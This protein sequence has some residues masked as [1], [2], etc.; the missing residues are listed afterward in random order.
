MAG[1]SGGFGQDDDVISGIN[2]TPLVDVVLVLL[3]IFMITAPAIYQTAI[4]VE[5]PSAKTGDQR[6]D[7]PL[8]VSVT[9]DGEMTLGKAVVSLDQ[10][11]AKVKEVIASKPDATAIIH[12][13][14]ATAHGRVVEIMDTLRDAGLF[15]FALSVKTKN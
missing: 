4:Q 13:D 9:K 3:V 2:V 12:A 8:E 10:I 14:R 15:R 7:T 11:R 6:A 5:L 1:G